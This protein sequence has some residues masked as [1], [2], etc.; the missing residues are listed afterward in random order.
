MMGGMLALFVENVWTVDAPLSFFGMRIGTRMTVVRLPSGVLLLHSPI[1]LSPSV[2]SAIDALGEVAHIVAPSVYHHVWAGEAALAYPLARI[3]APAALRAKRPELRI[4]AP[5]DRARPE[6]F[7][8]ALVPC[9]IAGSMLQ[10][11]VFVH[12]STRSVIS[13]D[14]SENFV[15]APDHLPTKLYLQAGGILGKPGWHRLLRV[16]YRDRKAARRSIDALLEHDFDA[17]VLAHGSP[18]ARGA[19]QAVRDTFTFL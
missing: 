19:K 8:G 3:H 13:S 9:A 14:L 7:E 10:E 12:P 1:A 16:V 2:R 5:L 18:I 11:T 17:L 15:E 4:D 6:D